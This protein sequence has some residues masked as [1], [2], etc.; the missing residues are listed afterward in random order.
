MKQQRRQSVG[1][2]LLPF[3]RLCND[4]FDF[5]H[6]HTR[7]SFYARPFFTL[8]VSFLPSQTQSLYLL[9]AAQR[10]SASPCFYSQSFWSFWIRVIMV[11]APVT[12]GM[13]AHLRY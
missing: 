7:Y 5:F 2:V 10:P 12:A 9:L 3:P 1:V 8:C 4:F 11:E 13:N 6:P